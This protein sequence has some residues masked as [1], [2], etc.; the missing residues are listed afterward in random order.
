MGY[1]LRFNVIRTEGLRHA[2]TGGKFGDHA[3]GIH[4]HSGWDLK[5][6]PGTQVCAVGPGEIIAALKNVRG[7]GTVVQ[8][9]FLRGARHYWALYA[10]LYA[11]F[12]TRG[13]IVPE[14]YV[15][16]L[17]G[18]TGNARGEV[19]HLHFEVATSESLKGGRNNTIDPAL[20]LGDFLRDNPSG[21]AIVIERSLS[22][23]PLTIDDVEL[24]EK[25]SRT[26]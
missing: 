6:Q 5:A 11:L 21:S 20:V 10:H 8:L 14:G 16:G 24:A 7:Y 17:T 22:S 4:R 26:S 19:P 2:E 15:L 12:V 1:P 25:I 23:P 18:T 9:K 3:R 13:Q